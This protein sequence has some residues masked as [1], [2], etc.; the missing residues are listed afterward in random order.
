MNWFVTYQW[1]FHYWGYFLSIIYRWKDAEITSPLSIERDRVMWTVSHTYTYNFF[2]SDYWCFPLIFI[3]R[4]RIF[5]E[6]N[7]I[8]YSNGFVWAGLQGKTEISSKIFPTQLHPHNNAA[9]KRQNKKN[10]SP[11]WEDVCFFKGRLMGGGYILA[12]RREWWPCLSSNAM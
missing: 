6:I 1:W 12:L 7:K 11:Q 10:P 4:G 5:L 3:P 8:F 9:C 2:P